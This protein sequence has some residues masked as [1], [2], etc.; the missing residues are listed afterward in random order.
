LGRVPLNLDELLYF[1]NWAI[2]LLPG[3]VIP[4]NGPRHN[5]GPLLL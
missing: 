4:L 3:L 1:V 2:S 5:R